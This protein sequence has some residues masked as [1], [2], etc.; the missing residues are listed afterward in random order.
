[1]R[2]QVL[3]AIS[4]LLSICSQGSLDSITREGPGGVGVWR[5]T[6]IFW[7]ARTD[8]RGFSRYVS[9]FD[10][11]HILWLSKGRSSGPRLPLFARIVLAAEVPE[12][13]LFFRLR[14]TM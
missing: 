13:A 11:S 12:A 4:N 9:R 14:A 10:I 8:S 5:K 2:W 7:G 6:L 1:M 3:L